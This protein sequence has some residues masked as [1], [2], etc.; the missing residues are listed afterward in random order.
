MKRIGIVMFVFGLLFSTAEASHGKRGT[1]GV[2]ST[3]NG[4]TIK[5][6][7][8]GR[9]INDYPQSRVNVKL[10]PG[11]RHVKLKVYNR[12][13]RVDFVVNNRVK[14][15]RGFVNYFGLGINKYGG[16]KVKKIAQ[17]QPNGHRSDRDHYIHRDRRGRDNGRYNNVSRGRF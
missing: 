17:V 6:Y 5:V 3:K 16:L 9:L 8:D 4:Q 15:N 2:F 14:V 11:T 1:Q 13:G 10:L 7:I 12:R